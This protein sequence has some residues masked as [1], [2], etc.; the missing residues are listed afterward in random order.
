MAAATI[1][2]FLPSAASAQWSGGYGGYGYPDDGYYDSDDQ[3]GLYD[4]YGLGS[5]DDYARRHYDDR[6]GSYDRDRSSP[7]C[8]DRDDCQDQYRDD[9]DYRDYGY[10]RDQD[11]EDDNQN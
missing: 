10:D 3:Q 9:Q 4:D 8:E 11:S 6:A 1:G 7:S 2:A 5:Y